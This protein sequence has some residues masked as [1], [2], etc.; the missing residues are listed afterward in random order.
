VAIEQLELFAQQ[1]EHSLVG[2][3]AAIQKIHHDDIVFLTIPMAPTNPLFDTL[4][5]PR[6]IEV[7]HQR[8][9]L[10]VDA[11]GGGFRGDHDGCS[12]TKILDN[13]RFNIDR[14]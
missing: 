12:I 9:E 2:F 6:Q 3:V 8:A 7:H 1:F 11:F 13:G 14:P 4:W 10:Q 5:I